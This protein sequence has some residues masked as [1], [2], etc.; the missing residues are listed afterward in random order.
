[1]SLIGVRKV[2]IISTGASLTLL[3]QVQAL[4]QGGAISGGLYDI[5]QL[6]TLFA[7]S[8]GTTPASVDSTV[9]R[10][11]DISGNTGKQIIQFFGDSFEPTLRNSGSEYYLEHNSD[12]LNRTSSSLTQPFTVFLAIAGGT[13]SKNICGGV[14]SSSST[15]L[16][17]GATFYELDAGSNVATSTPV[18][19]DPS[20]IQIEWNSSSTI[21]RFNGVDETSLNP[22]TENLTGWEIGG[23]SG[24]PSWDGNLYAYGI[25]DKQLSVSEK[26]IVDQWL[27]S[28]NGVSI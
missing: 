28:L 18:T 12:F 24:S 6:N 16:A 13:A 17:A 27:A 3:E 14:S 11:N 19:S 23:H 5:S 1:M 2:P 10:V 15:L 4:Y 25:I 26:S 9:G 7:D 21:F 22:G 20:V 8:A